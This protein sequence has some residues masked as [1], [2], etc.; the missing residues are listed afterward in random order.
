MK[1]VS[2]G[3]GNVAT[4]LITELYKHSFE[5]LQVYSRTIESSEVLAN[6]VNAAAVTDLK[7]ISKDADIYLFTLKDSVLEGVAAQLIGREGLW[8]HTAGS[9]S[10]EIFSNYTTHYGVL[11]PFQTF[12]KNRE[13]KW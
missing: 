9:V 13:V 12:S 7:N 8:I 6:K 11:Y 5:I 10:M 4:H 2:L 3:A 1:V